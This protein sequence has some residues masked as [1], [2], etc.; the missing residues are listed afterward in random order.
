VPVRREFERVVREKAEA[1]RRILLWSRLHDLFH[2]WHVVHKPFAVVMYVFMVVHVAVAV[3]TGY[4][5]G[6]S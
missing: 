1:R 6:T 3:W 5:W 4:T 2:Y